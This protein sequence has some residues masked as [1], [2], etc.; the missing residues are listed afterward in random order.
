MG[1]VPALMGLWSE[2][3]EVSGHRLRYDIRGLRN[4]LSSIDGIVKREL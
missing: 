2:V 1:S 3:D 4:M